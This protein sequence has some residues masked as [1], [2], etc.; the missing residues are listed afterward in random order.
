MKLKSFLTSPKSLQRVLARLG[1]PTQVQGKAP[2]RGPPYFASRVVRRQF[3]ES[4]ES[5]QLEM[6]EVLRKLFGSDWKGDG[7][8]VRD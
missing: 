2:A 8:P 6:L 4:D 5:A 1:E 7:Q 3:G